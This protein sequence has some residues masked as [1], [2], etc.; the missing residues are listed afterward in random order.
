MDL[1][2]RSVHR[3]MRKFLPSLT[4][5]VL[6]VGCGQSPYRHLLGPGARYFGID[7]EGSNHFEYAA[8]NDVTYF[9]GRRIPLG[10]SSVD[11]V[12]CTE[13][14]EH[15]PDPALVV[16][17][18]HRVLRK[19]GT[20]VFTVPWSARY[21]YIPHDYFRYTPSMLAILFKDFARAE[22]EARGTD[23]TS[24]SSKII[25]A[26]LRPL[27][28]GKRSAASLLATAI[29]T[30]AAIVAGAVG[31]LSLALDLGSPDDPLGYTVWITK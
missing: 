31:Q 15:C 4:G 5:D 22:V 16:Q 2:V 18:V 23:V 27:L 8:E 11:H 7:F 6:D 29:M 13:V 14:L 26:S 12:L 28:G 1:Q 20:G 17:E 3:D 9:D 30:P 21:H 25:V 10:D 24:I 19:G